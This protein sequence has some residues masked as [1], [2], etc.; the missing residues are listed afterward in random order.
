MKDESGF[1][2]GKK[3]Q[4]CGKNTKNFHTN[5]R[6]RP[7]GFSLIKKSNGAEMYVFR[8]SFDGKRKEL[9][10]G[11]PKKIP[12]QVAIRNY[13]LARAA[14]VNGEDPAEL[15]RQS[16]RERKEA[17]VQKPDALTFENYCAYAIKTIAG[18]KLWRNKKHAAQW[19]STIE[20]YAVPVIGK[21]PLNEIK[22][23]D[24]LDVLRPIWNEKNETATKVRGRL[25]AIFALAI[26]EEKY[27]QSNPATW[28][29]NLEMLLPPPGKVYSKKHHEAMPYTELRGFIKMLWKDFTV[30]R[31]LIIFTT[32][33]ACRIGESAP[34]KWSEFDFE[35][36]VWNCP[37]ERR[38]DGKQF[39]H[40]VPLSGK[41]I[42][43][44][45]RLDTEKT[46]A[47]VFACR[48]GHISRETPRV[49]IQRLG[50]TH[51]TMHGMRSSF[52]D[53]CAENGVPDVLA[54]KSLM[55]TVGSEVVQA[56]QRSD[57]LEQRRAVIENWSEYLL[58]EKED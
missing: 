14:L 23:G 29:G 9:S 35:N 44:L 3:R 19:T 42:E 18:V 31:A 12:Y 32:L 52:R 43:L 33:A 13:D 46:S 55:H 57:L 48:G 36:K 25:E 7:V 34:A 39:P 56:Y 17:K 11:S 54:E 22:R 5:K 24:I 2:Q 53:W 41:M 40:R 58:S 47:Y 6:R 16:K 8:Y 4:M 21:M 26:M 51:A 20:T 38:K 15:R 45:N 10:L 1:E 49:L 27:A 28:K 50:K 30:A 37:P